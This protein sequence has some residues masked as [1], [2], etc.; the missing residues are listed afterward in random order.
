MVWSLYQKR[1][2]IESI[3]L[4][5]DIPKLYLD[6]KQKDNQETYY[7]VDGQQRINA[8]VQFFNDEFKF[9]NE[10]DPIFGQ[11][12]SGLKYSELPRSLYLKFQNYNFDVVHMYNYEKNH[13]AEMFHRLQEGSSLNAAEKRRSIPGN[14]HNI[15]CEL[16]DHPIFHTEGFLNF[17]DN[18]A[19][20]EDRCAKIFHQFYH[21]NITTIKPNEVKQSYIDN[22]NINH[23]N[24]IIKNIKS[25]FNFLHASLKDHSPKLAKYSILRLAYLIHELKEQ[26]NLVDYKNEFGQAYIDFIIK[27]DEDGLKELELQNPELIEF[28]NC[29][30]GDSLAGQEFIHKH[31]K[32][33]ILSRIPELQLKDNQRNFKCTQRRIIFNRSKGKCQGSSDYK[34]FDKNMCKKEITFNDFHAD[35]I[36]PHSRGGA[37]SVDNGQALCSACNM[38]KS[39]LI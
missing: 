28:S 30:R 15:I 3:L 9:S 16:A 1:L 20:F 12:V 34:W 5:Y 18:R 22:E 17:K 7:I 26:Y 4:G 2:L 10:A 13:I 38:K 27:R 25:A 14:M 31:L 21:K 32:K 33:E 19:A 11:E 8:V 37:T 6:V 23:Q 36:I 24:P 39:N 35:H 29:A